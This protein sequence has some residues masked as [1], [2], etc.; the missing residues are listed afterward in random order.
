MDIIN[1]N[2]SQHQSTPVDSSLTTSASQNILES[3]RANQDD[4]SMKTMKK[5]HIDDDIIDSQADEVDEQNIKV[6]P[7]NRRAH[8]SLI[9]LPPLV[10]TKFHKK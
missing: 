1:Q 8:L 6:A 5:I 7:K 9:F 2:D 10:S 3:S 4:R